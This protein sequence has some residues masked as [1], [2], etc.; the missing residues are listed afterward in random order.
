[1][2]GES[3]AGPIFRVLLFAMPVGMILGGLL[4]LLLPGFP[5]AS[6]IEMTMAMYFGA[7]LARPT[8]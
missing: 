6:G 3:A 7:W 2:T 8:D 1:M 4:H 5:W